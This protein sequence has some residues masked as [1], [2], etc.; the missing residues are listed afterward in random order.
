[1]HKKRCGPE[2][3]WD[4]IQIVP[5][6]NILTPEDLGEILKAWNTLEHFQKRNDRILHF[7]RVPKYM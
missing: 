1:M 5:H 2:N 4:A 3:F 7:G 6:L